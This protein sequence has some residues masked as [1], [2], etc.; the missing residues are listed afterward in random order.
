ML[1]SIGRAAIRR[2]GASAS[3]ASTNRAAQIFTLLRVN[4]FP[5]ANESESKSRQA[6]ALVRLYATATKTVVKTKTTR[7]TKAKPKTK[8]KKPAKKPAKKK[9]I[10]KKTKAKKPKKSLRKTKKVLTEDQKK[11]IQVRVLKEKAL[12]QPKKLPHTAWTVYLAEAMKGAGSI[13]A[14][15]TAAAA[16]YKGLAP[17]DLESLKLR[18]EANKVANEIAH[19]KWVETYTPEQIKSANNARLM[20]RRKTG[21]THAFPR[22][23]DARLPKLPLH[24]WGQFSTER[25]RSGD[26]KGMPVSEAVK[27]IALE[28]KALS[29]AEKKP[30]EDRYKEDKQRYLQEYKT[31]FHKDS[32]AA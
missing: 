17:A 8:A 13:T 27:R 18:G 29:M 2:G 4:L 6:V 19:K 22:I 1:S 21:K 12:T 15:A 16:R 14:G 5:T 31:V 10:A 23:H 3:F 9:K 24:T 28:Y 25:Q 30:Y 11:R 7:S 26:F 20:L 32:R